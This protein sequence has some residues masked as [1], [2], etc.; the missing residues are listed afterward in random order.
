MKMTTTRDLRQTDKCNCCGGWLPAENTVCWQESEG[1]CQGAVLEN[2]MCSGFDP[3]YIDDWAHENG[4]DEEA[5]AGKVEEMTKTLTT[6]DLGANA[7]ALFPGESVEH[8][9]GGRYII[10][11]HTRYIADE[12]DG[13]FEGEDGFDE[14]WESRG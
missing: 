14:E 9:S 11:G 5:G 10:G 8:I 3:D 12:G 4:S 6:A 1:I 7:A 2:G 13:S